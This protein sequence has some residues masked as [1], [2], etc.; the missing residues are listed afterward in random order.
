MKKF[1]L[2]FLFVLMVFGASA[3]SFTYPD[4]WGKAGFNLVDSKATAV[5]IIYS[6]P[7][8]SLE[9]FPLNGQTMK[10]IVLPGSLLLNDEGMPNLPG[11]GRFIAIPQG[12]VPHLRIVSQRTLTIPNVDMAPASNIP[13]ESDNQP[14]RYVKNPSLYSTNAFYPANPIQIS[15][16]QKI[17]GVDVV[18][19]GITPFQYNPV[20]KKL[21]VYR[22]INVEISFTG[23]NGHLGDDAYR[24]PYWD[25][26]VK[27]Q[28]LNSVSLP[29]ID[30]N[31]RLQSYNTK[32][33]TTECE[34]IIITPT[35]PDFLQWADSIANFRNQQ[36]IITH[37]FT[38]DDVGG[39][40]ETAIEAFV[41]NAYTNWTIK[42]IACLLMGDYGT[43]ATKNI[44]THLYTHPA[45]YPKFASDNK[46]SDVDGDEMPDIIFSR[47]AANNAVQL[48]TICSKFLNYERNPPTDADF[49]DKPITAL[50]WQT[51]R[52]FQ[53]CSEVVGGFWKN[54]LNKHPRR[55]NAVN[56]GSQ[57]TWSTATNTSTV[58]GYFGPTGLNYIPASPTSLGGWTGG[59]ATKINQ[60]VDSGAFIL[61]HRDHGD[62][63]GWGEPAYS[64]T[65][66][67]QLTNTLLPFVFSINCETGAYHNPSGCPSECFSEKFQRLTANGHNAGALGVV[68]PSE[69]SYSFVNDAFV[70]GMM[71]NMWP[72][73]MPDE[74]TIFP[75]R[76]VMPAFA[77]AAGKYFLQQSNWP[78]NTGD[79]LV[80]YRLFHMHGDA[81]QVI[82][83]EIPQNLTVS[84]PTEISETETSFTITADNDAD[85]ALTVN[86]EIIATGTGN[87]FTPT[88]ISIPAQAL[89]TQILVTVTK[90]NYFRYSGK[91]NVITANLQAN[92]IADADKI[93]VG[94]S[95]NFTDISSGSPTTWEWS[96]DG[97]TPATA[98]IQNPTSIVY[99]TAGDY[100]VTL[101][102]TKD[103]N[104]HD[105]TMTS[106]IHVY[107]FPVADFQATSVCAGNV[108]QFT[109]LSNANGGT[110]STWEWDF[111]DG[112]PVVFEQNPSHTYTTSGDYDVVLKATC[113]G[114]C[115]NQTTKTVASLVI[116]T[117]PATP[118]GPAAICQASTA[119]TYSTTDAGNS[120][121]YTWEIVPVE[122]GSFTI[123]SA[124]TS[125]DCSSS[126]SGPATIKVQG[127]NDCGAGGFSQELS[128]NISPL[129][130]VATQP[131]G[132]VAVDSYKNPTS[133]FTTTATGNAVTYE[134]ILTQAAGSIS[135]TDLTGIVTWNSEFRGPAT[136]AV[137]G[138][139]DCGD[140]VIS[141][142]HTV[143]VTS[144]L[145]ISEIQ[146]VGLEIF[147][148]PTTG[149]F[150][151]ELKGKNIFVNINIF[152]AIGASVYT[153]NNVTITDKLSKTLDFSKMSG[154]VYTVKVESD[155][156]MIIHKIIIQK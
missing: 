42:P 83:S 150:T 135:G 130:T 151:L 95:I 21:L 120:T 52:W 115:L 27:D 28:I 102:I 9:D 74:T 43:D 118:A 46:Y 8:F 133:E 106:Y 53:L 98:S 3:Q 132:P 1:Y 93:C 76:F 124:S 34:Y 60:A 123:N 65:N 92:F 36:G 16:V 117:E 29:V 54:S 31:K 139:N 40:S 37:I 97:G 7:K 70:W 20:T 101:H 100:S 30:Y 18:M 38:L 71:D 68:C 138:I 39:N 125:L 48:Q 110:L 127:V 122:A 58:V 77:N 12:A 137:R 128:I 113:N 146:G 49:Y 69:V 41:D 10:T 149:K 14:L 90:Q 89:G 99:N 62:Y 57:N 112:S 45:G 103:V 86:N 143:T 24:S 22:D 47:I 121:T 152:N 108:T 5:Q 82:Y 61:I 94:S 78:Y 33:R 17:R 50:G 85:I 116:P 88:V 80:T 55:I 44:I 87:G 25:P 96:F 142:E 126:Y 79:K 104:S 23:G 13:A 6:I 155:K 154:G 136:V 140:G 144:T 119:N 156:G 111:G 145:G 15:G 2:L 35:G 153:E 26:I 11:Q 56:S 141:A 147:P 114:T 4:A 63:T 107:N 91:V 32:S 134:W 59:T 131:Q 64:T 75:T 66:L 148:N 84:H 105:T 81:F 109:D 129:P 72:T 19:L 67:G 51:D 73:F